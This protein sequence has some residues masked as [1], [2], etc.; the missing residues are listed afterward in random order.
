MTAPKSVRHIRQHKCKSIR[1]AWFKGHGA[2]EPLAIFSSERLAA[3]QLLITTHLR[4]NRYGDRPGR[5][6]RRRIIEIGI[7]AWIY[8]DQLHIEIRIRTCSRDLQIDSDCA[9]NCD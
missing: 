2:L 6:G 5:G 7:V 4:N 1:F 8:I 3:D 9:E